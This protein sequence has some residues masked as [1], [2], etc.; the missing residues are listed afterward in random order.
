MITRAEVE[1]QYAP[2]WLWE[3]FIRLTRQLPGSCFSIAAGEIEPTSV[4]HGMGDEYRVVIF[5]KYERYVYV[6]AVGAVKKIFI[7][8]G[9]IS[10]WLDH[11]GF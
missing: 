2:R 3:E 9:K 8:Q 7:L 6:P 1:E 5:D 10:V 4:S 11:L